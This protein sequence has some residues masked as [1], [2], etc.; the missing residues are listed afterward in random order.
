MATAKRLTSSEE[1]ELIRRW[2]ANRDQ[3]ALARLV[4]SLHWLIQH[5]A[6]RLRQFDDG[7][8]DLIQEG[9]LGAIL[10]ID[11]FDL[12]RT[13]K[14]STYAIHWILERMMHY[15]KQ[16]Q[17]IVRFPL[18]PPMPLVNPSLDVDTQVGPEDLVIAAE[19]KARLSASIARALESLDVRER[20]IVREHYLRDKTLSLAAVGRKLGISRERVRQIERRAHQKL[21]YSVPR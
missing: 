15:V 1:R 21:R 2:Q 6:R 20:L 12:A 4:S 7:V 14:L 5:H 9:E 10:A 16:N 17:R 3:A 13:T 18:M 11:R 8:E 19:E